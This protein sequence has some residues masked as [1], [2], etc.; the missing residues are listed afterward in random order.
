[1]SPEQARGKEVDHRSDIWSLGVVLYEMF[2]GRLPFLGDREASILYSVV[3]EEP[4]PIKTIKP[5][6]APELL[7]IIDRAL[8]K[9]P[10]SRYQSAGEMLKDLSRYRDR[11]RMEEAGALTFG[12]FLQRL[13]KPKIAIPAAIIVIALCSLAV[14]YFNRRAKERWA[15]QDLL[16]QIERLLTGEAT[17]YWAAYELA[18]K[19]E[20]YVPDDPFFKSLLERITRE[21]KLNSNPPGARIY[22]KPYADVGS[23]WRYLGDTPAD[24]FQLPRGF[25]RIKLEKEGFRT[26]YDIA[27]VSWLVS[28]TLP[29]KLPEAGRPPR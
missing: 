3:H 17:N 20:K 9:N 16:P 14:W 19:A 27:W 1:M 8:K 12:S 5:G 18:I 4:K 22:A 23:D 28:D 26:D 2:S 6:I 15:R 29:Y 25:S 10:E 24:R 7:Q 13:R 11:L 21:V